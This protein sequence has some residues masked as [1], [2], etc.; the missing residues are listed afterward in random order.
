MSDL[1]EAI[2]S[3]IK[4]LNDLWERV[5]AHAHEFH[6]KGLFKKAKVASSILED[7]SDALSKITGH[8]T[9]MLK[10][11]E[12]SKR[13]KDSP[14]EL[15]Y[16]LS[17]PD[18]PATVGSG[19]KIA[20]AMAGFRGL[21]I[22]TI[23]H[24]IDE[25]KYENVPLKEGEHPLSEVSITSFMY[26][27]PPFELTKCIYETESDR[28]ITDIL[29]SRFVWLLKPKEVSWD[30]WNEIL[31]KTTEGRAT[32]LIKGE[33]NYERGLIVPKFIE[34]IDLSTKSIIVEVGG[35]YQFFLKL[36]SSTIEKEATLRRTKQKLLQYLRESSNSIIKNIGPI[37]ASWKLRLDYPYFCYKGLGLSTD[38]F[39]VNCPFKDRCR[40]S[41]ERGGSCNGKIFWSGNYY[42]RRFYPKS[43]P[44]RKLRIGAGGLL[45]YNEKLPLSLINFAAYEKK[46]VESR[47]YAVEIGTW[48]INARPTVRI[49]FDTEIGYAIPTS[50]MEISF[51]R[52][53]LTN[54][55]REILN[56]EKE[57][58]KNIALK[59]ILY[60]ALGRTLNYKRL[61]ETVQ[62]LMSKESELSKEYN[63][64][65]ESLEISDDLVNFAKRVLLHSMEH[66]LTQYI[67]EKFAGVDMSFIL[68]KYYHRYSDKIIL[69]ENAK[70]GGIGIVDTIIRVIREN[71]LNAFIYHFTEWLSNY[72]T[73]HYNN[74]EK[75]AL[76][77]EKEAEKILN[78]TIN[79]L[80]KGDSKEKNIARKIKK[81][82]KKVEEFR[83][84]LDESNVELDITLARTVLLAGEI[85]SGSDVEEIGD[86][87]DD[88]LEKYGFKLCLDGCNGCVRLERYCEE[89]IQQILTTSRTLLH[90]FTENLKDIIARGITERS[91]ELGKYI[92]PILF[93]A[94]KSLDI[95]CPY[96]SPVYANKLVELASKGVKVRVITWMPKK[97]DKEYVF[98]RESLKILRENLGLENLSAKVEDKPGIKLIHDKTYIVDNIV[99]TGSFNLTESA[100]Y[101]NFERAEIKLHPQTIITEKNQFEELWKRAT[102]LS[103]YEIS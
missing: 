26:R 56:K 59:F 96:I 34:L 30:S 19:K 90:K 63:K 27:V 3:L 79:R 10:F 46:R 75:V 20:E 13:F 64:Y 28:E 86:Y 74:F 32:S 100:F 91:N 16:L 51:E 83:K 50:V 61:S 29:G 39:D 77:R 88:I 45:V 95:L 35:K 72:L 38:P 31:E 53:W 62:A 21:G 14:E 15:I 81:T 85:L 76:L 66:N 17:L 43:Y 69:A 24:K 7:I 93:N 71:G 1:N 6:K 92:E 4:R 47:W 70:N 8:K 40:L 80:E 73:L 33:Y 11:M 55:V 5:S 48:F 25:I 89:G 103:K 49:F 9:E 102:D 68:T 84:K 52:E 22:E 36:G 12:L 82:C 87:F 54:L 67:L 98:Q 101:G 65:V 2:E 23:D 60:K 42:R 58:R 99:I 37:L 57:V 41:S 94:K 97:E 18:I 44:L 78:Q